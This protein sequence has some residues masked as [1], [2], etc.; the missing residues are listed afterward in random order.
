M[1]LSQTP[2][3]VSEWS[4][5]PVPQVLVPLSPSHPSVGLCLAG[6]YCRGLGADGYGAEL[7]KVSPLG[8]S[9]PTS[10]DRHL[11][12]AGTAGCSFSPSPYQPSICFFQMMQNLLLE[13]GGLVQVE[14]VN[15]QVATYSKFQ[16]QSPDFLDITNPKA[17]YP[18]QSIPVL[19]GQEGLCSWQQA[20]VHA[21]LSVGLPWGPHS[22][23]D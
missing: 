2:E 13:E 23:P 21:C 6:C 8:Q 18:C 14:S 9:S 10:S 7:G 4:C 5:T 19:R 15:L 20:T 17:V 12:G 16:P 11:G 1:L 3:P 22:C